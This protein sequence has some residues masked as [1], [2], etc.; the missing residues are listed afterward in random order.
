M[1]TG[2]FRSRCISFSEPNA[3]CVVGMS[4]KVLPNALLSSKELGNVW[5]FLEFLACNLLLWVVNNWTV[6]ETDPPAVGTV[7]TTKCT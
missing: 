2:G 7:T 5:F 1:G 4:I 6:L 3:V